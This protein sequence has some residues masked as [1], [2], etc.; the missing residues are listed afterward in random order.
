MPYLQTV[1]EPSIALS[2]GEIMPDLQDK[3]AATSTRTPSS[4]SRRTARAGSW[5]SQRP[6]A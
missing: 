1:V 5:R 3:A 2:P 4:P 6:S